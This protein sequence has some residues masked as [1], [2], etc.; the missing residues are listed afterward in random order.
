MTYDR[1]EQRNKDRPDAEPCPI[2]GRRVVRR[3]SG[4]LAMHAPA[5]GMGKVECAG[6]G[7]LL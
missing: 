6:T 5:P 4:R 3:R 1:T 2:C 7:W